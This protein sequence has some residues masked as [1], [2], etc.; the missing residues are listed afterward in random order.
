M[1]YL[2]L[3]PIKSIIRIIILLIVV[4]GAQA[5]KI[6]LSKDTLSRSDARGG[7]DS[8]LNALRG[9]GQKATER[10]NLSVSKLKEILDACA[11]K[12][13]TEISAH[14]VLIRQNDV[15]RYRRNHP[16]TTATDAEIR[17]SQ[18]IVF[19][20]PRRAFPGAASGAKINQSNNPLMMSLAAVG[21]VNINAKYSGLGFDTSDDLF[22]DFGT[23]CPP[24]AAC[25]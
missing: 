15:A 11:A 5:Q 24:P 20:V 19:R 6:D 9:S 1:R 13:I 25:D 3:S 10:V 16:E 17:G 18:L 21:L 2:S 7:R 8:Y 22:F 14:M 23:I 12:G 4:S